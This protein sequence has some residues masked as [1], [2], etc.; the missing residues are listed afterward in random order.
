MISPATLKTT[1]TVWEPREER[2]A[3]FREKRRRWKR[4]VG[5]DRLKVQLM[6]TR[7]R[8]ENSGGGE[9]TGG[10]YK[11]LCRA[12]AEVCEG[13]ILEVIAGPGSPATLRV[14]QVHRPDNNHTQLVL[15]PWVGE[16]DS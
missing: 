15:I 14:E 3:P 16:L 5:L 11:A 2:G 6:V 12:K 1:V 13:D 8:I 7:E 10:E 4:R 9:R